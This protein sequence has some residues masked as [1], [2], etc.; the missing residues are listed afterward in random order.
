MAE[1]QLLDSRYRLEQSHLHTAEADDRESKRIVAEATTTVSEAA[2]ILQSAT[3]ALPPLRQRNAEA[4]AEKQRLD[5]AMA[6]ISKEEDRIKQQ[7]SD[8]QTR[9]TQITSDIDRETQL[10]TDATSALE[11]LRQ[12]ETELKASEQDEQPD[13]ATAQEDRAK[14][15][16]LAN[17]TETEL[18]DITARFHAADRDQTTLERQRDDMRRRIDDVTAKSSA[19]DVPS[20]TQTRDAASQ[21]LNAAEKAANDAITKREKAMADQDILQETTQQ[22]RDAANE[23]DALER[24]ITGEIDALG[25]VTG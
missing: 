13:L 21:A 11:Q 17:K 24:R 5:M 23:A 6:D 1:A 16:D 12:E 4:M 9:L 2:R 22:S 18:A 8:A 19:L 10:Q 15:R 14:A 25:I 7:T 3:E 20:L